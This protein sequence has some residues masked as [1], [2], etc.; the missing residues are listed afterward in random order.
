MKRIR[1]DRLEATASHRAPGYLEDVI[2]HGTV[3][4]GWL[5]LTDEAAAL[6]SQRYSS[7]TPGEPATTEPKLPSTLQMAK[8]LTKAAIEESL[9]IASGESSV[10]DDEIS[11]RMELCQHCE[12]FIHQQS[13]CSKCGCFMKL[14]AKL[15]AAH[16]PVGKW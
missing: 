6:L 7:S 12:F 8:N 15:R 11:R 3:V 10:A 4:E 14:K 16:C 1:L 13:R 2:S 9:S 5:N